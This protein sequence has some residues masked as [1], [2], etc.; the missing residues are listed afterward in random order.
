MTTRTAPTAV[1]VET[2]DI[3]LEPRHVLL[4]PNIGGVLGLGMKGA[5]VRNAAELLA[6]LYDA[7]S[8]PDTSEQDQARLW[9]Q[10]VYIARMLWR[11]GDEL[12]S[13]AR[14]ASD[15]SNGGAP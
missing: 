5:E 12:Y 10:V 1:A 14:E 9:G 3:D 15:P 11:T 7:S 2:P 6:L 13:A 4:S 8:A